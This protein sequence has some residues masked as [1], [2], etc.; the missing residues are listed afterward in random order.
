MIRPDKRNRTTN[1]SLNLPTSHTQSPIPTRILNQYIEKKDRIERE[2]GAKFESS[3]GEFSFKPRHKKL[4]NLV[5][6]FGSK[7]FPDEKSLFNTQS[8]GLEE[9]EDALG[10]YIKQADEDMELPV[11][12]LRITQRSTRASPRTSSSRGS[13]SPT[14]RSKSRER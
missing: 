7:K 4:L 10:N 3:F 13:G 1:D 5:N 12:R 11:R 6:G 9:I 2:E 14:S 8:N